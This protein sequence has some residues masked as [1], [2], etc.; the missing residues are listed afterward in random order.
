MKQQKYL[1]VRRDGSVPRW[2][3]FVIA[4]ADPAAGAALRAYA[5]E[6]DRLGMSSHYTREVR[7]LAQAY[8]Q[9][10]KNPRPDEQDN[11][12]E[13]EMVRLLMRPGYV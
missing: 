13:C 7:A 10:P 3:A 8:D 4:A 5:D 11:R 6:A 1:V 9:H 12:G 2:P